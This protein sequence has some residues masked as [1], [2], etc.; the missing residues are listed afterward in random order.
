MPKKTVKK[1]AFQIRADKAILA[2]AFIKTLL[3]S[4]SFREGSLALGALKELASCLKAALRQEVGTKAA[5]RKL[6]EDS[7]PKPRPSKGAPSKV[8]SSSK[9]ILS[10]RS[11]KRR[12][13]RSSPG[14]VN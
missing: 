9:S 11:V 1:I 6:L 10:K 5:Q 13:S 2:E 12:V 14:S 4:G 7:L 8:N 3:S